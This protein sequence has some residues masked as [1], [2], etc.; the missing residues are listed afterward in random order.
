[1]NNTIG[2]DRVTS[3]TGWLKENKKIGIIGEFAGGNNTVCLQA[4]EGMLTYMGQN[5]DVW[6]GAL[7]WG[8]G[9]WWGDYIYGFEPPSGVAYTYYL[10]TLESLRRRALDVVKSI[11]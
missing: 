4:V 7:W 3:A 5:T 2:Q 6:R 8:G 1:M 11:F 9:P 10:S